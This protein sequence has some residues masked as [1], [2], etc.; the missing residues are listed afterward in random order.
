MK[1]KNLQFPEAVVIL[2][3]RYYCAYKL[4][5]RDIEEICKD[6]NISLDHSTIN[7]WVIKFSKYIVDRARKYKKPVSGKW[8]MDET[9]IK[10]KGKWYYYYRV[11]DE[12]GDIIDFYLSRN[13]KAKA[14]KKFFIKAIENNRLPY[15]INI[16]K[17]GANTK[18]LMSINSY[19]TNDNKIAV[20]REKYLNNIVEQ[21]HRKVKQKSIQ[22]LGYKSFAGAVAT[23]ELQEVWSMIKRNQFKNPNNLSI[24]E[25]F[26]QFA[27]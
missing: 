19:L 21:S 26:Y 8:R 7:R 24:F 11:V 15:K 22:A 25:Q 6:R 20:S 23:L 9:Y 18:A 2:V 16:D 17:S 3:V 5:Y 27:A 14:A 12:N 13:R 1:F 4:S 10:I